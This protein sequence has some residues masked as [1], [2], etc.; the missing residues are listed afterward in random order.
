MGY[1]HM[2]E[3]SYDQGGRVRTLEGEVF[4][5]DGGRV[6]TLLGGESLGQMDVTDLPLTSSDNWAPILAMPEPTPWGILPDNWYVPDTTSAQFSGELIPP[7]SRTFVQLPPTFHIDPTGA[8]L[9]LTPAPIVGTLHAPVSPVAP[10]PSTVTAI[11]PA[12][13][14]ISSIG[15]LFKSIFG[16]NVQASS[17]QLVPTSG[18]LT[19]TGRAMGQAGL[20]VAGSWFTDP[21]QEVVAGVPNWGLLGAGVVVSMIIFSGGRKSSQYRFTRR[22]N[23]A[24]LILM[25]ANP[26]RRR[27]LW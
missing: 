12:V 5:D 20:L 24:E 9:D 14:V 26:R 11:A 4:Y 15:N 6:R 23:P 2:G 21:A 7:P 27:R 17:E 16:G 19:P 13:G 25:G 8:A 18:T 22:K 1:I 3:V 10:H